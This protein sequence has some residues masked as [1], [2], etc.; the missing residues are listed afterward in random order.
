MLLGSARFSIGAGKT[1]TVPVTLDMNARRGVSAA[2]RHGL[3]ALATAAIGTGP[4]P[5]VAASRW[6]MLKPYT[7]PRPRR[8]RHR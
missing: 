4:K 6:L 5:A 3:V 7:P 2:G 8:P 1:Q